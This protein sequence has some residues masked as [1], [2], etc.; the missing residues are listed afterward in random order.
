[1]PEAKK[2]DLKKT[3]GNSGKF[4]V[5]QGRFF[6]SKNGNPG[7]NIER[8]CGN[9]VIFFKDFLTARSL[10]LQKTFII[11]ERGEWVLIFFY[12]KKKL[13]IRIY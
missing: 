6:D 2:K 5:T 12:L 1:M 7:N 10:D 4:K 13:C 3:Q 9:S 11:A 8:L